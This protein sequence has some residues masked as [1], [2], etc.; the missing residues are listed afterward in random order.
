MPPKTGLE[1]IAEFNQGL[2]AAL[3]DTIKFRA[4]VQLIT[5]SFDFLNRRVGEGIQALNQ[6]ETMQV[7]LNKTLGKDGLDAVNNISDAFVNLNKAMLGIEE[8]NIQGAFA[9]IG[10]SFALV[11]KE[12]ALASGGFNRFKDAAKLVSLEIAKNSNVIDQ[13]KLVGFTQ[14][15]TFQTDRAIDT[16][17]KFGDRLV[18]LAY[19]LGLPNDALLNLGQSLLTTGNYFGESN[20]K[21]EKATLNSEAFGRAL[22]ATGD[23]INK[24]LGSM[25]TITGRQQLAARLSQIGTMV[26]VGIDVSKLMSADPDVQ[27]QGLQEALRKFSSASKTLTPAQQRGLSL[28]LSRALPQFGR[29]A[30]QTALVRGVDISEAQRQLRDARAAGGGITDEMRKRAATFE[31]KRAQFIAAQRRI[32]AKQ[33]LAAVAGIN[34]AGTKFNG[35]SDKFTDAVKSFSKTA[36]DLQKAVSDPNPARIKE[37]AKPITPSPEDLTSAAALKA[38]EA[39]GL[40]LGFQAI[41]PQTK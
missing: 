40:N 11:N 23:I 29:E 32:V 15:F 22:G 37:I 4:E 35:A 1:K 33:Q 7:A 12:V 34:S 10:Q 31:A 28:T 36:D 19:R 24:Q 2:R 41:K 27:R 3:P 25:Q 39:I 16:S 6:L 17:A 5:K 26:G 8:T 20:D 21:I 30:I 9:G 14:K 13:S 18:G 38:L